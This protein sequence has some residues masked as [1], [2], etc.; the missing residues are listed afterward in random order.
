M[1]AAEIGLDGEE[2]LKGKSRTR[3]VVSGKKKRDEKEKVKKEEV[4]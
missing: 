1:E 4:N 3:E 2:E